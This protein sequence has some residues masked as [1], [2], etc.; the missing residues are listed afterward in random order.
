MCDE[1]EFVVFCDIVMFYQLV[2][3]KVE[4]DG[5]EIVYILVEFVMGF[6]FYIVLFQFVL[7]IFKRE[8]GMLV[9]VFFVVVYKVG[10]VCFNG[11]F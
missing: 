11:D 4:F 3:G 5:W 10:K 1:F 6:E 2:F 9:I 7:C 8:N